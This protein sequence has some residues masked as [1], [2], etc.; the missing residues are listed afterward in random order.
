MVGERDLGEEGR[1][2]VGVGIGRGSRGEIL[3]VERLKI[4]TNTKD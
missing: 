3:G 2:R 4:N 1:G